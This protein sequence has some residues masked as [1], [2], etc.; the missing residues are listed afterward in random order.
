MRLSE[1]LECLTSQTANGIRQRPEHVPASPAEPVQAVASEKFISTISG[2]A[3][4]NCLP[5]QSG[6]QE[7]RDLGG[8]G[9]RLI[10]HVGQQRDNVTGLLRRSI[11]FSML[12]A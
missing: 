7:S 1:K 6:H 8:I 5:S 12:N 10:V 9:K 3:D 4:R 2:Q 11:Q